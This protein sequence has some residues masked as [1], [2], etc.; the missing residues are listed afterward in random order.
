MSNEVTIP[1]QTN[2][3]DAMRA[4]RMLRQSAALVRSAAA[5]TQ[6]TGLPILKLE[7]EK[8]GWTFGQEKNAF[9]N[10]TEIVVN[11]T[12]LKRGFVSWPD[13]EKSAAGAKTAPRSVLLPI[14]QMADLPLVH[15]LPP[16]DDSDA[17]TVY[18]PWMEL[19]YFEARILSGKY[20]GTQVS[21]NGHQVGARMPYDRIVQA[22]IDRVES[23]SAFCF[24]IVRVDQ[25]SYSNKRTGKKT[26]TPVFEVVGW[27]D[28]EGNEEDDDDD[29]DGAP[30][31]VTAKLA[32][33]PE[34]VAEEPMRRRRRV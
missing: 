11:V 34:P 5:Q 4:I 10:G 3:V 1:G 28:H 26:Y 32:P 16:Q 14:W 25:D 22:V 12:S 27:T 21:F 23:D 8:D 24:P 18:G 29:D 2:P 30:A 9:A 7:Q 6:Y 17:A 31:P 33:P 15:T 13:R 19:R 20:K